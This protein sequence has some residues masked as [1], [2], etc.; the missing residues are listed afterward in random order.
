MLAERVRSA[1]ETLEVPV[2]GG[3]LRVTASIG[4]AS[5]DGTVAI[6][7]AEA[8]KRADEALYLAK[9]G[10]RNRVVAAP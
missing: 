6:E 4:V 10:G 3:P 5:L 1:I 7:P 8:L 2:D 9:Q